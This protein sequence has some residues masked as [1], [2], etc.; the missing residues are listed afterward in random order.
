[1]PQEK[2]TSSGWCSSA[3]AAVP[4]EGERLQRLPERVARREGDALEVQSPRL[5]L[6]EVEDVVEQRGHEAGPSCTQMLAWLGA[7]VIKIEPPAGEP[8]ASA[9]LADRRRARPAA[10]GSRTRSGR[11]RSTT[12]SSPSILSAAAS[13]PTGRRTVS[14][15]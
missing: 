10:S 7:D 5:D 3:A 4:A 6:G 11:R 12:A 13:W 1:M 2:S 8:G 9:G 14:S 15:I